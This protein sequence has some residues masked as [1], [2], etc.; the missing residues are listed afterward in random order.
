MALRESG[1]PDV[2]ELRARFMRDTLTRLDEEARVLFMLPSQGG[3]Q[4]KATAKT[5]NEKGMKLLREGGYEKA[6]DY[7]DGAIVSDR[8]VDTYWFNR[9]S[10]L[11][12]LGRLDEA[13]GPVE[14]AATLNPKNGRA[15]NLRGVIHERKG[16]YGKAVECYEKA[17][18][19]IP[20][21]NTIT[22][23]LKNARHKAEKTR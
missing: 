1:R 18:D 6:L 10:C 20:Q 13:V 14:R 12:R 17:H 8:E 23:N 2:D 3:G 5:M 16:E 22:A 4:E 7:F 9:A 11:C 19:L 21:N 15:F